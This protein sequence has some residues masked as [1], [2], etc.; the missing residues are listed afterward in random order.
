M[1]FHE[2]A[3]KGA[4]VLEIEKLEDSRGFFSRAFCQKEFEKHGL[5]PGVVQTNVSYNR[6]K[7]T[8]RGMHY[9]ASPYGEAKLVRCTKGL[10]YDVVID[11]RADSVTYR[12]WIGVEL[13]GDNHRIL[14]VP[15]NFAHG[16]QTLA[17][18]TEVTYQV[19]QFYT[20][21]YE[22]GVRYD[23]PVF[24]INWPLTVSIISEKDKNWQNFL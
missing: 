9:Q 11:L 21:G 7:G 19:S 12:Q 3:L 20:P 8:L 2:T 22:R 10:I 13:S 17:D 14:Y 24:G 16:F 6:K 1:I 23:D 4:F 15:E 5:N 18:E